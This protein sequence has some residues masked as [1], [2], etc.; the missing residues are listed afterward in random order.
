[1]IITFIIGNLKDYLISS[2]NPIKKSDY[3]ITP[4]LSIMILIKQE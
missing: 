1:M 3:G 2:I 4:Y